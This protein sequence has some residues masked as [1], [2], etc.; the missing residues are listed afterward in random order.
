MNNTVGEQAE[1]S[2]EFKEMLEKR[3]GLPVVM[4]DERLTTM[5]GRPYS[6]GRPVCI[7]KTVNSIWIR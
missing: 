6:G 5:A 1:K 3:T 7:R 2:L 4:W